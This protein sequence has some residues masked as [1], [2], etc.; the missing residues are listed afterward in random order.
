VHEAQVPVRVA[1]PLGESGHPLEVEVAL[2][3]GL[4]LEVVARGQKPL[5]VGK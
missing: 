5:G 3:L 1:Q 2:L 4:A